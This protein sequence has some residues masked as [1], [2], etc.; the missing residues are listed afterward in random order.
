MQKQNR[1]LLFSVTIND[2]RVDV[3]R[4]TG[5]GGQKRNRT[6]SKVRITHIAS[7]AVGESDETRD[8]HKNKARAFV[9]MCESEKFKSWHKM[10]VARRTGLLREIEEEVDRQMRSVYI[11]EEVQENGKWVPLKEET[12]TK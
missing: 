3:M 9:K 7:G 8:Q 12:L 11:R 2:C 1:E 4:G 6:E 5:P 10:E